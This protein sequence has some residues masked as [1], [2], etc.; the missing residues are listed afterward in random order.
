MRS[1]L[2][3]LDQWQFRTMLAL[4][5][6]LPLPLA[7]N[8]TWAIAILVATVAI[9]F[10]ACLFS[11]RHHLADVIHH[12][13]PFRFPVLLFLIYLLIAVIQVLPL[14]DQWI[15]FLSPEAFRVQADAGLQSQMHLS[16][17]L[18]Q[19]KLMLGLT[20]AYFAVFVLILI[21]V[22]DRQRLDTLVRT[23]VLSG[24]LQALLGIFLFSINARYQLFHVELK[25]ENVIGSFVNRNHFAGYMEMTL[26]L[27]IGLMI[28]RLG[29]S[30][31]SHHGV[32]QKIVA[33][34]RFLMSPKMRLRL[35]LVMM[36]IALVL[37][38][39]RM[40]NTAFFSSLLVVGSLAILLS[41]RHAPATAAL[42]LSLVIVDVV[43]IGTWV[44]L[45]KV[46]TR[47]NNTNVEITANQSEE[48]VE[49]RT[50][51]AVYAMKLIRDFPLVG[52]G[53]G[54]FYTSFSRYRP[55]E[56]TGYFDHAHN[57]YVEIAADM[58]I[59]AFLSLGT[60]V[61][62]ALYQ[63]VQA[64]RKRRSSLP[65]GIA[66][67]VAMSIVSIGIHS[68]VDFNLQIPAN[69]LSFVII[70]ALAWVCAK[71]PSRNTNI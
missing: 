37:T 71:L 51:P 36:V 59:F 34:L 11:W 38:R 5:V 28:A 50:L 7:S 61:M 18:Y 12:L 48:S 57:D 21:L 32:K 23:F 17:D 22:R 2:N 43:V 66:F 40:G 8:R 10:F 68:A 13:R 20:A 69:A 65:R 60:L 62:A 41:R 70:L 26:A 45:E 64:I 27:G 25:H 24:V 3:R 67:G 52:T 58:G 56:V 39:S 33:G 6:W 55:P 46:V 1:K 19:S 47:I 4:I 29:E 44:G 49:Q 53:A 54:S 30:S 35:L 16:L 14:P 15:A 63:S 31:P 42:I 9:T